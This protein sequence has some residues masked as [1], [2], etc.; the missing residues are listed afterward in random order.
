[1]VDTYFIA[2]LFDYHPRIQVA[3]G[4]P[5]KRYAGYAHGRRDLDRVCSGLPGQIGTS[6]QVDGSWMTLFV[7]CLGQRYWGLLLGNLRVP[8]LTCL[9]N[10]TLSF[11]W[12][13]RGKGCCRSTEPYFLAIHAPDAGTA[14]KRFEEGLYPSTF[15]EGRKLLGCLGM[16][17]AFR[18]LLGCC[19][20]PE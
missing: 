15:G 19:S 5:A 11:A 6:L 8:A 7:L 20:P 14:T 12:L 2:G 16:P 1:M 17:N 13:S 10:K 9:V 4:R 18:Q 3:R